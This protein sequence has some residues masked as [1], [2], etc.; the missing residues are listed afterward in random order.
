MVQSR[1][2]TF[3][4]IWYPAHQFTKFKKLQKM[5]NFKQIALGLMVGAMAIGFSSFTNASKKD[6]ADWY[7]PKS[8]IAI[9]TP[10]ASN[11]S[12]YDA[13]TAQNDPGSCGGVLNV[14]AAH[15]PVT[16]SPAT[17]FRVKN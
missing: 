8:T 9:G 4:L 13:T 6:V 16:T 3:G 7:L 1:I 11:F 2:Y 14:C 5:K 15:F 17:G 10:A 12:N